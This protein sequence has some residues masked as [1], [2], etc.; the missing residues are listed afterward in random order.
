MFVCGV[1]LDKYTKDMQFV[2]NVFLHH[3]LPCSYGKGHQ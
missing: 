1:N 3:Q 2:S